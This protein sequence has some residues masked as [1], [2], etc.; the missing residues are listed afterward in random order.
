MSEFERQLARALSRQDPGSDFT[1]RVVAAAG[2][3]KQKPSVW[4]RWF[5]HSRRQILRL[6]P[7]M[8]A[9]LMVGTGA[10]FEQ[11]Q[12][13]ERG[14]AAK[15]QLLTAMRIASE[16]LYSTEKRVISVGEEQRELQ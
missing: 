15:Q 2:G 6:A 9:L 11:H 16:K 1:A 5:S 7:A 13:I 10:Y 8:T 14:E 3:A 4:K 12:R